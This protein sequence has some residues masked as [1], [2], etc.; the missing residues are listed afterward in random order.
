MISIV[1]ISLL[2]IGSNIAISFFIVSRD[3]VTIPL[4]VFRPTSMQPSESL[5]VFPLC[6]RTPEKYGTSNS[7]GRSF[8]N[9]GDLVITTLYVP[10]GIAVSPGIFFPA[11]RT[12]SSHVSQKYVPSMDRRP[13]VYVGCNAMRFTVIFI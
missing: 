12:V 13:M 2:H 10:Y 5:A 7:S 9:L 8:L 4:T 11:G 1:T 6:M 3:C